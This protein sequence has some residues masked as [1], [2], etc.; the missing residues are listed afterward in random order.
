[1]FK[2]ANSKSDLSEA[3][4]LSAVGMAGLMAF[5]EPNWVLEMMP[6]CLF[7]H[8]LGFT[9]CWG[10]GITRAILACLRGDIVTA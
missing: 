10:C 1:M 3:L 9:H 6:P 7:T 4:I 5:L 2:D 8:F